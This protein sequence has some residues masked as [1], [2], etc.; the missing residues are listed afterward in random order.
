MNMEY[1]NRLRALNLAEPVYVAGMGLSGRS[2][3]DVLREA[4]YDAI[5]VDERSSGRHIRRMDF[6]DGDLSAAATLVVSPGIDRRRGAFARYFGEMIND[7]ELFARIIDKPVLAVTGSNGKSTVVT[8]LSDALRAAGKAT[9]LCGNIG[10]PVLSALINDAVAD[11]YVLELSSYQL[12]LCPSLAPAVGCVLNVSPDHL[13][14]YADL[15]RYV[16]AKANLVRQAQVCVL[17]H[18]DMACRDMAALTTAPRWFG[19]GQENDVRDGQ[20]IIAGEARLDVAA[21]TL[22][23]AHNVANV[24]A[25]LAILHQ[26]TL[27]NAAALAAIKA[28]A[29][30]PHRMQVTA[31][32]HGVTWFNDSKATNCGA[33]EA[34]LCGITAPLLLILGG[35]DKQQDFTQ[36][37][38]MLAGKTLRAVL[39][40]G[41]RNDAL[42]AALAAAGVGYEDCVT[43]QRAVARARLLAQRGDWVVLSPACASFD[44]YSGYAQRGEDF[45]QEVNRDD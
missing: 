3:L 14:R 11:V 16:D 12:E 38:Q 19:V 10:Y 34:A 41:E 7:V 43:M 39:L 30:L 37:A 15:S 27:D 36:L 17:N 31:A 4:G 2:A 22:K 28:F 9:A 6:D 33:T 24:V 40:I 21:L 35:Q 32:R 23:G 18:D 45:M 25:V 1:I 26:L 8:L 44:Q 20:V 13:D 5:G 42:S 29:G